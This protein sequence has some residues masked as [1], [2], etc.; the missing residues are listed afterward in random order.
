MTLQRIN[1]SCPPVAFMLE[2]FELDG[3]R[4]IVKKRFNR[5]AKVGKNI[6]RVNRRGYRCFVIRGV[7]MQ[8][9]RVVWAMHYGEWPPMM[10]DHVDRDPLNNNIDNLRLATPTQN[11]VNQK[12]MGGKVAYKGVVLHRC[13]RFQVYCANRYL[14]L[15]KD[16]VQAAKVYDAAAIAQYGAYASVNFPEEQHA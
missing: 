6:V 13:G 2:N 3:E 16:P 8:F 15:Y 7:F 4:L 11:R 10:I 14:G 5:S 12:I 9:H 1:I